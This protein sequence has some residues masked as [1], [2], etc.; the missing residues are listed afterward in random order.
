MNQKIKIGEY[1]RT[2]PEYCLTSFKY[3]EVVEDYG[4]KVVIVDEESD[5]YDDRLTFKKSDLIPLTNKELEYIIKF[6]NLNN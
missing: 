6:N 5:L 4:T 2:T 1:V 3:G